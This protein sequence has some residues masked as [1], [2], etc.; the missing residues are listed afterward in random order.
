MNNIYNKTTHV[1]TNFRKLHIKYQITQV[2][3]S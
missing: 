1:H 2:S 3:F